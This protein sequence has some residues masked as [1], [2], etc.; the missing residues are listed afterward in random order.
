MNKEIKIQQILIYYDVPQLFLGTDIVDTNYLCLLTTFDEISAEYLC[1]SISNKRYVDLKLGNIDLRE[2]FANPETNDWYISS[3][4]EIEKIFVKHIEKISF[5]L[6][7]DTGFYFPKIETENTSIVAESKL[8]DNTVIQ[9]SISDLKNSHS[10]DLNTFAN[11]S[12]LYQSLVKQCYKTAVAKRK[13]PDKKSF[14]TRNNYALRAFETSQGSFKIHLSSNSNKDLFGVTMIELALE[15]IDDL[16]VNFD[17]E[18]KLIDLFKKY[19]G[20]TLNSLKKFL[21]ELL[22][23]NITLNYQWFAPSRAKIHNN[24]L[25]LEYS[26]KIVDILRKK[27]DLIQEE[28]ILIGQFQQIDV[29]KGNW[30]I[31][32][33]ED[34]KEY[35][36]K[37]KDSSVLLSGVTTV[38]KQY[39]LTCIEQIEEVIV[40]EKEIFNYT[41]ISIQ[42]II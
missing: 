27:E 20:H 35:S 24:S 28:K 31:L 21:E 2:V 14:L 38:T 9:L 15:V 17:D 1:I 22:N 5:D 6:L 25:N 23:S 36:G 8:Y 33:E 13:L 7:P 40:T 37:T 32:N 12:K 34:G 11:I 30:R 41:L 29:E 42:E 4:I 26:K 16:T 18:S 19:K 10:I 3:D 39:Q